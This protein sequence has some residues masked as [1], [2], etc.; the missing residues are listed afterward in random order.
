MNKKTE[1]V[2][3]LKLLFLM[4][5]AV[6]LGAVQAPS[7]ESTL[8]T[9]KQ[10]WERCRESLPPFSYEVV[11]DEAITSHTDPSLKLRRMEVKFISQE[12]N[13]AKMGHDAV[14]FMPANPEANQ[15]AA[16][17]GKVVVVTRSYGDETIIQLRHIRFTSKL[18]DSMFEFQIPEGVEI[19]QLDE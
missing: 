2:T 1:I 11:K 5:G 15:S 4:T 12:I 9:P 10:L 16:R 17:R 3:A 19:L 6:M 7:Q 13:G 8:P 14:I 18:D